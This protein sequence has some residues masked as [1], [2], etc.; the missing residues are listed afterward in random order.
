MSSTSEYTVA[1]PICIL[2]NRTLGKGKWQPIES[3]MVEWRNGMVQNDPAG[4]LANVTLTLPTPPPGYPPRNMFPTREIKPFP[5]RRVSGLPGS[6]RS[7]SVAMAEPNHYPP[8]GSSSSTGL[9]EFSYAAPATQGPP[10]MYT[11]DQVQMG[12][13]LPGTA[14]SAHSHSSPLS[15]IGGTADSLLPSTWESSG[16]KRGREDEDG[17]AGGWQS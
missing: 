5:T 11:E 8:T 3:G 4:D 12:L 6:T 13:N 2:T 9:L 7:I 17:E 16:T 1:S 14:M 15:S 10:P